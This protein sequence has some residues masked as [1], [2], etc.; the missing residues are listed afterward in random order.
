MLTLN[1]IWL[2]GAFA[3]LAQ[4]R[5]D[6]LVVGVSRSWPPADGSESHLFRS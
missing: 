6:A 2:G 4:D 5:A 3:I 1:G